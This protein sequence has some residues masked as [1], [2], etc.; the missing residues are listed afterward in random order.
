MI[1]HFKNM[2]KEAKL[3][4]KTNEDQARKHIDGLE[5]L[6]QKNEMLEL[7]NRATKGNATP[8]EVLQKMKEHGNGNKSS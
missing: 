3:V 2:I 6:G 8:E 4:M 1:D 5:D 7:L